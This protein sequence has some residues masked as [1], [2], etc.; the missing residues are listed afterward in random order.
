MINKIKLINEDTDKPV[1]RINYDSY[2]QSIRNIIK[3]KYL[4]YC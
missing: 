1:L 3:D 2:S 4:K